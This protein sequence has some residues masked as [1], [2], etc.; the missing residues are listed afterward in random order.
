M[1]SRRKRFDYKAAAKQLRSYGYHVRYGS[2]KKGTTS[3]Q[4]K[5]AVRKI[6]NKIAPLYITNR[7]QTFKFFPLKKKALRITKRA[8]IAGAQATPGGVFMRVPKGIDPANYHYE[9][10]GEGE[11][12]SYSVGPRG[13]QRKETVYDL[14][15]VKLAEDPEQAVKSLL[16]GKP[17]PF[18]ARLVVNGNE[19][20]VPLDWKAFLEYAPE[21]ISFIMD[22]NLDPSGEQARLHGGDGM[23]EEE[24]AE[25]FQVKTIHQIKAPP[26]KPRAK[27]KSTKRAKKRKK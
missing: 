5:T 8:S 20:H 22:P 7:K 13:G 14:D 18:Q 4:H 15:P 26:S 6:Y 19:A 17:K 1:P 25:I 23:S 10:G 3:A 12:I 2:G 11:I 24:F 16:A 27:K 9:I 21:K